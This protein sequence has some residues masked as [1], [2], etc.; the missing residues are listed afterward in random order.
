MVKKTKRTCKALIKGFLPS[1]C[2]FFIQSYLFFYVKLASNFN[3]IKK[4]SNQPFEQFQQCPC[5]IHV[6]EGS[7]FL[8]TVRVSTWDLRCISVD[9]FVF[10][11]EYLCKSARMC[12]SVWACGRLFPFT[13]KDFSN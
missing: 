11:C 8:Q 2:F 5:K 3:V 9:M 1:S 10:V 6:L 13:V 4:L 7:L 12:V